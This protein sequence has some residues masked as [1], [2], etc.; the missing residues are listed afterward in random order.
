[1]VGWKVSAAVISSAKAFLVAIR[2]EL[3]ATL[4]TIPARVAFDDDEKN[5]LKF[6]SAEDKR[7]QSY[8]YEEQADKRASQLNMENKISFCQGLEQQQQHNRKVIMKFSFAAFSSSALCASVDKKN[9]PI[10]FFRKTL[11]WH[12]QVCMQYS[13][14]VFYVTQV[15][16][17]KASPSL[18]VADSAAAKIKHNKMLGDKLLQQLGFINKATEL[19]N[20]SAERDSTEHTAVNL[21]KNRKNIWN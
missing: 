4:S 3:K 12:K 10:N 19:I 18:A 5:C 15:N 6:H 8:V 7:Q 2:K 16:C 9:Y 17:K 14:K 13:V 21:S 11:K 20:K 1:M